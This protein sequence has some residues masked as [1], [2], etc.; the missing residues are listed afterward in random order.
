[1][2]VRQGFQVAPG[3]CFICQNSDPKLWVLDTAQDHPGVVQRF[4]VY[5]CSVCVVAGAK[6]LSPY[7]EMHSI[8]SDALSA[9]QGS[10]Q[11]AEAYLTR[12]ELAEGRLAELASYVNAGAV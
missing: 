3:K 6:M 1:M 11:Q 4:R 10:A 2:D 9:L 12:A 5:L 8:S 7:T